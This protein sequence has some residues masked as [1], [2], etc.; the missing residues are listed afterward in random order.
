MGMKRLA[1]TAILAVLGAAGFAQKPAITFVTAAGEGEVIN[2]KMR[3][4]YPDAVEVDWGDGKAER[5]PVLDKSTDVAGRAAGKT[6]KIYSNDIVYF[7]CASCGITELDI[8]RAKGL[9]QL[10]CG[11]NAIERLD[12]SGNTRLVR[13]GANDNRLSSLDISRNKMLKGLFL[14]NNRLSF[15]SLDALFAALPPLKTRNENVTLRISGNSGTAV[16]NSVVAEEKNWTVDVSGDGTGGVAITLVTER[17]VG[18]EMIFEVRTAAESSVVVD[19]GDGKSMAYP[20]SK[21]TSRIVGHLAAGNTVTLFSDNIIYLGCERNAL[22]AVDITQAKGLEQFYCGYNRL[23]T[24]DV[25]RNN[26]LRRLGATE[27]RLTEL[28]LEHHPDLG[29]LYIQRNLMGEEA[30]NRTIRQLPRLKPDQQ[31]V[32]LRVE[33]NTGAAGCKADMAEYKNWKIDILN[34]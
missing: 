4:S 29:G 28:S 20:S 9:Q 1:M 8:S 26:M 21:E 31:R 30:L 6:V 16:C 24:L 3:L 17:A 12:V 19:W 14:Q 25:S 32:N 27:N 22:T 2:L 33:G 18:D 5:Y 11:R 10:Y 34:K 23:T 7:E 13:I 15:K